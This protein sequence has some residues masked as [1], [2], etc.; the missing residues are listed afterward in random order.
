MHIIA[1]SSSLVI[2]QGIITLDALRI[3]LKAGH[4]SQQH[5]DEA[6]AQLED[7]HK[8]ELTFLDFLVCFVAILDMFLHF[9]N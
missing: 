6:I 8:T 3:E 4:I 5:E 9:N 7:E 1:T 2:L